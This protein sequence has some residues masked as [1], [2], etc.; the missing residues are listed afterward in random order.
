MSTAVTSVQ[1]LPDYQLLLTFETGEK[2]RFDVTPYLGRGMFVQLTDVRLFNTVHVSFDTVEW[3]NGVD[4]CPEV[5]Y[6][7][8]VAV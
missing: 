4:I 3:S 1:P 6:E 2:R 5:L 7:G 8:S